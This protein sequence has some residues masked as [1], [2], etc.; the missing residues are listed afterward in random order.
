M[1]KPTGKL[2]TTFKLGI[3]TLRNRIV[4]AP[5]TRGRATEQHIP[6][7][8]MSTYYEQRSDAGL[9]ITEGVGISRQ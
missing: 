3:F 7:P 8:I 1:S 6:T 2:F 5:M 9:L 4:L